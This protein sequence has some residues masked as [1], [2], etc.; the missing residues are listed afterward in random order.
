MSYLFLSLRASP[1]QRGF[2]TCEASSKTNTHT[3]NSGPWTCPHPFDQKWTREVFGQKQ[4]PIGGAS[5]LVFDTPH[6]HLVYA[7]T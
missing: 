7:Y 4:T 6:P 1:A 2:G 5:T 3:S